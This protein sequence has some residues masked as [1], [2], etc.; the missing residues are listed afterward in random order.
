MYSERER[1][2]GQTAGYVIGELLRGRVTPA[3][4]ARDV[5]QIFERQG[6]NAEESYQR[7][8]DQHNVFSDATKDLPQV[9]GVRWDNFVICMGQF[10]GIPEEQRLKERIVPVGRRSERDDLEDLAFD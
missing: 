6:L 10:L 4:A 5:R 8:I 7:V 9:Q 3:G 2:R 1:S